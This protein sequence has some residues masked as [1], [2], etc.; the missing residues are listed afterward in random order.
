MGPVADAL[1]GVSILASATY[2][3]ALLE[4]PPSG[5]R[6]VIKTLAVAMIAAVS[7]VM[8]GPWMLTAPLILSAVGDAFLAG[9]PKRWL[10]F[11]LASFLLAHL[12]YIGLFAHVGLG[13]T[14]ILQ[15]PRWLGVA[16]VLGLAGSVLRMLW[17]ALG[18]MRGAVVIYAL[19]IAVM[20][21]MALTLPWDRS[22]AMIGA[23]LFLA[24]D[25][26]LAVRL[27]RAG[28]PNVT[29]DLAVW[30]FYWAAQV[31]IARAFLHGL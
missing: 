9:D 20:A 13:L 28:G 27:F 31:L 25:V 24:S 8:G 21:V 4:K 10:P 18:R 19:V 23:A 15:F 2:G 17:P 29:A 5:P 3:F 1:S 22:A 11:G 7:V 6:T 12:F 30:W 26:I 16:L 14:G